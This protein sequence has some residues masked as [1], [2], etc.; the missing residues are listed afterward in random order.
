MASWLSVMVPALARRYGRPATTR[1]G[2]APAC[3]QRRGL[4]CLRVCMSACCAR[5]LQSMREFLGEERLK[6]F[7]NFVLSYLSTLDIPVKR[8]ATRPCAAHARELGNAGVVSS[9]R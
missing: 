1:R 8:Y 3:S 4:A 9:A 7:I 2:T 6:E 5:C